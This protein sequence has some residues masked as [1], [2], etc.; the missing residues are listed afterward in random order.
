[1][2]GAGIRSKIISGFPPKIHEN[3][4]K[5][6]KTLPVVCLMCFYRFSEL[7]DIGVRA[8]GAGGGLQPPQLRKC[9]GKTLVIRAKALGIK[10]LLIKTFIYLLILC[11][12]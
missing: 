2:Y 7:P 1:L 10:Y 12:D 5:V 11:I 6:L 8:G 4:N 9:S 3:R